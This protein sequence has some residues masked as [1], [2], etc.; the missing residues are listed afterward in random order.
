MKRG[1][2]VIIFLGI[3]VLLVIPLTNAGFFDW[4]KTI[5]GKASSQP[6]NVSVTISGSNQA[7][8][9]M[10]KMLDSNNYNP[11]QSGK[12]NLTAIVTIYDADGVA[13]INDSSVRANFSKS[14]EEF[15]LNSSCGLVV[16]LADGN[17]ANFSCTIPL[18]YWDGLGIWTVMASGNDL[19]NK[20]RAHNTS[21]DNNFTYVIL[22]SMVI[23][24]NALTWSSA[25][26][27]STDQK[28]DNHPTY[29]NNTGNYN[30]TINLTAIDLV[31]ESI[32]A[33]SL[34]ASNFT[35]GVENNCDTTGVNST[36][37]VNATAVD[38]NNS[39]GN[40]GN[41]S[42]LISGFELLYYCIPKV[43]SLSSQAYSTLNSASWTIEYP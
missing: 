3:F 5:T 37:L 21:V 6:T 34:N 35:A 2:K 16:D 17:S 42:N 9:T 18:W 23:S 7:V 36:I 20:V 30:S 22:K 41:L 10:I 27:L 1:I 4:F 11:F 39:A 33:E 43:P 32:Q 38:M 31:G 12:R 8:V 15:R 19:G 40:R 26:P 24:P 25:V 28:A 29:V 13:D 14:G